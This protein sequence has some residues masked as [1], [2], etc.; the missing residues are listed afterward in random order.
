VHLR[1]WINGKLAAE[2]SDADGPLPNGQAGLMALLDNVDLS[3]IG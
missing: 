3:S 1:F 2:V